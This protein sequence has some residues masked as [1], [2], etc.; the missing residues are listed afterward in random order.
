VAV[1]AFWFRSTN[2]GDQLTPW[3]VQQITGTRAEFVEAA[4]RRMKL[5]AV[6]SI[7][8]S[9]RAPSVMWGTGMMSRHDPTDTRVDY[10][11]VRG[12]LTAALIASQGGRPPEVFGDPGLLLPRW[13]PR[14]PVRHRLGIVPHYVHFKNAQKAFGGE[15][16]V[17]VIDVRR[18]VG[19]VTA[20]I[21]ACECIASSSLH[22]LI[23]ACAYGIPHV[24]LQFREAIAG[25]G[26]K[27]SDFYA[28]IGQAQPEVVDCRRAVP[29][30]QD[31]LRS[32]RQLPC[33][34]TTALWEACPVRELEEA[35]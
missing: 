25:D 7:L 13:L 29:R 2:Y 31:L 30:T 17:P 28:G 1:R 12:P 22:G 8:S 6:G 21:T 9:V 19:H 23:A 11:A 5:V 16:G 26:S 15:A 35:C 14:S 34:D 27:F 24:R 33:P 32:M 4:D 18:G 20:E 10:R 3:I